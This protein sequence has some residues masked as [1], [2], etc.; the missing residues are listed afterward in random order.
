MCVDVAL[1]ASVTCPPRQAIKRLISAVQRMYPTDPSRSANFETTA[2]MGRGVAGG[3]STKLALL[4]AE[5]KG[6]VRVYTSV[7]QCYM[8]V[9]QCYMSL[10]CATCSC[11]VMLHVMLDALYPCVCLDLLCWRWLV[12]AMA[13]VMSMCCFAWLGM[14]RLCLP[15]VSETALHQH[16]RQNDEVQHI[17]CRMKTHQDCAHV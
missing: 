6:E 3:G 16:I 2:D 9:V 1:T 8:S 5:A 7:I 17:C 15:L 4:Q 14:L 11:S 12:N 10:C 13:D